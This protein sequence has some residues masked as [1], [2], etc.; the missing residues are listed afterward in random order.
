M[1]VCPSGALADG[2]P[3]GNGRGRRRLGWSGPLEMSNECAQN[4]RCAQEGHNNVL[5]IH[6]RREPMCVGA[7]RVCDVRECLECK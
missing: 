4:G 7:V 1:N 2:L 3:A 6:N 5:Y